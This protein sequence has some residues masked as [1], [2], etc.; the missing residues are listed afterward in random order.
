MIRLVRIF[1][2][3][4]LLTTT[5]VGSV[6]LA[7]TDT[8]TPALAYPPSYR[9]SGITHI[10][11][12]WNNCGPATLT[13]G[14]SYFGYPVTDQ[15]VAANW[16]K[17]NYEDKNVSP[18]QMVE[19]VNTQLDGS[20]RAL[21]RQGGTLDMLKLLIS[22]DFAVL[23]EEGYDPPGRGLGWMGHY[24]LMA[25]YDDARQVF[26]TQD[27]YDGPNLEYTYEHVDEFWRHFNHV[28]IVLY[29][30]DREDELMAL[31]GSD[32][33]EMQ[34]WAN[35]LER[36]R[37]DTIADQS[38]AFNWFNMGTNFVGLGMY[39]EAATAY[40]QARNI[41]L[42]WRM[43]WYQFGMF[44]TYLNVGRFNDVITLAQANLNDGGGQYV[45]ETFYY[46]GLAREAMGETARAI[47]NLDQAVF[48]NPN[49]TPALD[50]RA[51]LQGA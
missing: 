24:L 26:I 11:Q 33:D 16:L 2:W 42:P 15:H 48:F 40:D 13:M 46:G 17:P 5:V 12:D 41:G 36:A 21:L 1:T 18:W 34:N 14:L 25:G 23:T 10:Y 49:F 19:Y 8:T 38:D 9:L 32:A 35:A 29:T 31:L 20:I 43:N 28:Y 45:E 51:E 3:A 47:E 27:S 6:A 30:P 7:Q 22:N 39:Q 37:T 4:I 50:A 44:E